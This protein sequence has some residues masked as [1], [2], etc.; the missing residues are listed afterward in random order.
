MH[1]QVPPKV[2]YSLTDDGAALDR[3]LRPLGD[4]GEE[5]MAQISSVREGGAVPAP[6][7]VGQSAP[8]AAARSF[9]SN[10]PA[11]VSRNSSCLASPIWCSARSVYPASQ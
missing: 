9:S 11:A 4:W 8:G 3:A 1:D 5:R 2:V 6:D 10:G 7:A